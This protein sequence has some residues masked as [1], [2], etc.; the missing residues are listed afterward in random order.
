MFI[1]KS[2][3][4]KILLLGGNEVSETKIGQLFEKYSKLLVAEGYIKLHR[5]YLPFEWLADHLAK[6]YQ[7]PKT[8][9]EER[10]DEVRIKEID[11]TKQDT[12]YKQ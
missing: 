4:Q 12:S 6:D 7:I 8:E 10:F 2:E 1:K 5:S 11:E 3:L 9:L